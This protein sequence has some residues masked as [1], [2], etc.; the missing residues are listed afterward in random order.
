[1][2]CLIRW[3]SGL[4]KRYFWNQSSIRMWTSC[5]D[6]YKTTAREHKNK[7]CISDSGSGRHLVSNMNFLQHLNA[8]NHACL[9]T[10]RN[11]RWDGQDR[12]RL[13]QQLALS[14]GCSRRSC[15]RCRKPPLERCLVWKYEGKRMQI[16]LPSWWSGD[17]EY[18]FDTAIVCEE[19]MLK[20]KATVS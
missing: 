13:P 11:G 12:R 10:E 7:F 14:L 6:I 5:R 19:N 4:M 16:D 18:T 2:S 8:T 3:K 15:S 20:T 9:Q 1:M 17:V